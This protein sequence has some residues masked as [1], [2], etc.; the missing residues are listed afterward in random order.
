MGTDV[1]SIPTQA[2]Y[3]L[4]AG[5]VAW[6]KDAASDAG[7]SASEFVRELLEAARSEYPTLPTQKTEEQAA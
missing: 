2:S 7:K 5:L 6:V 3:V 4:T 1:S